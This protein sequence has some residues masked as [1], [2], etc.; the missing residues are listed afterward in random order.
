[1]G[2]NAVTIEEIKAELRKMIALGDEVSDSQWFDIPHPK[3]SGSNH[4]VSRSR[5][6]PWSNFGQIAYMSKESAAFVCRSRTM[7][8]LAC[9]GLLLAIEGLEKTRDGSI[10]ATHH[11]A[12]DKLESIRQLWEDSK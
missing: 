9:K 6:E 2:G 8:P 11:N 5:D 10:G 12:C 3:W 7:T 4:R 1:M